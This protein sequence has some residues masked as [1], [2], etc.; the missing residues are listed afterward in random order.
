L[1]NVN[2]PF[3]AAH[4]LLLPFPQGHSVQV[5]WVLL[6]RTGSLGSGDTGEAW[7]FW[8][9]QF[10]RLHTVFLHR[11]LPCVCVTW[12]SILSACVFSGVYLGASAILPGAWANGGGSRPREHAPPVRV[13]EVLTKL[14]QQLL[15]L[16]EADITIPKTVCATFSDRLHLL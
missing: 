8:K 7:G 3:Y 13:S 5:M 9:H 15:G 6:L 10:L 1:V 12:D 2:I 4:L 11:P 16:S 14:S